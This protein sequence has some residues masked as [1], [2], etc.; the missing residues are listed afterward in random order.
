M[1]KYLGVELAHLQVALGK[2][3]KSLAPHTMKIK[4]FGRFGH[5]K[6]KLWTLKIQEM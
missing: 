2:S 6:I 4:G 3:Y 5:L 1:H